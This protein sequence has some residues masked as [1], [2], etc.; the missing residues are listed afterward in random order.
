MTP[1][2]LKNISESPQKITIDTL[3]SGTQGTSTF[4]FKKL[5]PQSEYDARTKAASDSSITSDG[6]S[7]NEDFSRYFGQE[8][9]INN[10]LKLPV[11]LSFQKNQSGEFTDIT[12]IFLAFLPGVFLFVR[13]RF[14]IYRIMTL[15][16][17]IFVVIYCF[18]PYLSNTHLV[19]L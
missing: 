8:K 3:L 18:F 7:Q 2:L 13:S 1:W 15:L 17:M 5:Y 11:N 4:D 6:Q 10:Y 19:D 9:G 12:Y 16:G 14:G